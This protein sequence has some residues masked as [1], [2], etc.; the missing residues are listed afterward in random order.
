MELQIKN[1]ADQIGAERSDFF[2]SNWQ[3]G[4]DWNRVA[5]GARINPSVLLMPC[6]GFQFYLATKRLASISPTTIGIR[7]SPRQPRPP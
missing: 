7:R 3:T 5:N 6:F 4:N 2:A 1:W